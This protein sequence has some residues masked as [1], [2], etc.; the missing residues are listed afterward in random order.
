M[1]DAT[2]ERRYRLLV[3]LARALDRIGEATGSRAVARRAVEVGEALGEPARIVG[4]LTSVTHSNLW[5]RQVYGTVDSSHAELLERLLVTIGPDDRASRAR[6]LA[7]LAEVRYY[8]H[9]PAMRG[10]ALEAV[11]LARSVGD[12]WL[13]ADVA[14]EAFLAL[15]R[16]DE[17]ATCLALAEE[18][19]G[20]G[21]RERL[22]PE[23]AIT[24]R[25]IARYADLTLGR[26][27]DDRLGA[28]LAT[29]ATLRLPFLHAQLLW[30]KAGFALARGEV[31]AA[32][33]HNAEATALVERATS[34]GAV[35]NDLMEWALRLDAGNGPGAATAFAHRSDAPQ[36]ATS[37]LVV[38]ALAPTAPA[39]ARR[40]LEAHPDALPRD[41]MW[42]IATC[43]EA[44]AA[45]AG[46]VDAEA[47]L[48]RLLPHGDGL[49]MLGTMFHI[50]PV[51]LYTGRLRDRLGDG[52][53]AV[54]DLRNA[55]EVAHRL[56]APVWRARAEVHL[57]RLL[58]AQDGPPAQ[59]A[60]RLDRARRTAQE[61]RAG[62]V[63]AM[64]EQFDGG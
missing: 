38:M 12:P 47:V 33:R 57:A 28:D 63:A 44:E 27:L 43:C 49:A 1:V 54:E 21:S 52:A 25:A 5:Y 19:S 17:V 10:A 51:A 16:P 50:G 14:F 18:L 61:R 59:V 40:V 34:Y 48:D 62:A 15:W 39:E 45:L 22:S 26:R 37:R 31:A 8:T 36:P 42:L 29:V 23:V 41:W 11:E 56:E 13:L 32:R 9:E 20:V 30:Q 3:E 53:G 58:Q 46:L 55:I 4:A 6:L 60:E 64:V 35:A 7:T 24:G 2:A